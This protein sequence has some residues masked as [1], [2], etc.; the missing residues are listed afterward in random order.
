MLKCL[1]KA[2]KLCETI[3]KR[4]FRKFIHTEKKNFGQVSSVHPVLNYFIPKST[5]LRLCFT[6]KI[7]ERIDEN[8]QTFYNKMHNLSKTLIKNC[9]RKW[10]LSVFSNIG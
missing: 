6:K 2:Y 9:L 5:R 1:K 3:F 7:K 8:M 4:T 10:K